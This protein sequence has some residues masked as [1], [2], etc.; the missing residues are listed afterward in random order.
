MIP[1]TRLLSRYVITKATQQFALTLQS[2][3]TRTKFAVTLRNND[4]A[5]LFAV[6]LR[7]NETRTTVCRHYTE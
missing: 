7:G 1:Q 6:T 4:P 2:N 3:E 5:D